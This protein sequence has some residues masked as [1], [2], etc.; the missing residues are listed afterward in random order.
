MSNLNKAFN[1]S[2]I[3][4]LSLQLLFSAR[5]HPGEGQ[6]FVVGLR[7]N[8]T[9]TSKTT[10]LPIIMDYNVTFETAN[11]SKHYQTSAVPVNPVSEHEDFCALAMKVFNFDD[12]FDLRNNYINNGEICVNVFGSIRS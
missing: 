8:N 6:K 11:F 4:G 5:P 12:V 3:P 10:T 9:S 2:E 7:V 1:V